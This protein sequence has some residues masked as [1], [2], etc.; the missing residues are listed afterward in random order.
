[1][2]YILIRR[3]NFESLRVSRK[4]RSKLP[5]SAFEIVD[6]REGEGWGT[7]LVRQSG[8]APNALPLSF[9]TTTSCGS[10]VPEPFTSKAGEERLLCQATCAAKKGVPAR[11][12]PKLAKPQTGYCG[13]KHPEI[14]TDGVLSPQLWPV[15]WT[16]RGVMHP[17]EGAPPV[18][19]SEDRTAAPHP[20]AEQRPATIPAAAGAVSRQAQLRLPPLDLS[21]ASISR[22]KVQ[23]LK[24]ELKGFAEGIQDLDEQQLWR[25]L[26][27][28][29][30][31]DKKIGALPD[32]AD[33]AYAGFIAMISPYNRL[34]EHEVKVIHDQRGLHNGML[35]QRGRAPTRNKYEL[36]HLLVLDDLS[37]DRVTSADSLMRGETLRRRLVETCLGAALKACSAPVAKL[38]RT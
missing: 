34:T 1:M 14:P 5:F 10:M 9:S 3:I 38:V 7:A 8:F 35:S 29:L 37:H 36:R 20:L 2:R 28:K 33:P 21:T 31:K 11:Q 23:Q 16:Q 12:C 30:C 24:D 27:V 17:G 15:A 22:V 26:A 6:S 4:R 19:S 25:L 13:T 18:S 32:A